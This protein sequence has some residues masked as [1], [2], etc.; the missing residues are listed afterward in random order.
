MTI[1]HNRQTQRGAYRN[2]RIALLAL[3]IMALQNCT[4]F[5]PE[6]PAARRGEMDL[7]NWNFE[8]NGAVVLDGEWEFYWQKLFAPQDFMQ[9]KTGNPDAFIAVPGIWNGTEIR[10]TA[11]S[12]T[13]FATYRLRVRTG[14]E[15]RKLGIK[16][17]DAATA[18]KLW[19]NGH[20][21]ASN[22][23]VSENAQSGVPQYQPQVVAI[24]DDIARCAGEEALLD[25]VIQVSNHHHR[26]GGL[27]E[28]IRLG[29]HDQ[30]AE[31]RERSLLLSFF[32][33][34]AIIIMGMYHV[35][36]YLLRKKEIATLFFAVLA[37]MMSLRSFIINERIL[38][39]WFPAVNWELLS[40]LEYL[41]S[42]SVIAV[43]A[44][45]VGALYPSELKKIP[46]RIIVAIGLLYAFLFVFFKLKTY[47]L[48][49][50][51]YDVYVLIGGGYVIY[52]LTLA[53]L[54]KR[55]GALIALL[56][57]SAFYFTG[58]NDVLYNAQIINTTNLA[59][60]GLFVYIF[61]QSHLLSMRFT[62]ALT[63]V[64]NMREEL[65]DL[66]KNLEQKVQERTEEL[67]AAFE[68]LEAV[69]ERLVETQ[70][71]ILEELELARKIQHQLIPR[72]PPE[73]LN[74]AAHYLPMEQVGGDFFDY[75]HFR[76]SDNIG[77]FMSDVS[78]H[79]VPAAL[80]TSMLKS[81]I[82]QAGT[83]KENPAQLL[84]YLNDN[85]R[86]YAGGN[87][88]TAFYCICDLKSRT[89][90]YCNAGH[91]PPILHESGSIKLLDEAKS[92]PLGIMTSEEI[93]AK[94]K[95][96]KNCEIRISKGGRLILYTDGISDVKKHDDSDAYYGDA[97]MLVFIRQNSDRR[98]PE[99]ID[100]FLAHARAYQG[101]N[102]F[103]D[104]ICLICF[105]I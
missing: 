8:K 48:F 105:D 22:G 101:R 64:E 19:V 24:P 11:I 99:F 6:K 67:Q 37:L 2:V 61:S 73:N 82:L 23:T 3:L 90:V 28:S 44:L 80:I 50:P 63:A 98:P 72:I 20:L 88:I 66:N 81:F 95:G 39:H 56:G 1:A 79:G 29:I 60:Y 17:L 49:K 54:R 86:A 45:F 16:M 18:Y 91:H 46:V 32:I 7:R 27:W 13:G 26:K 53:S 14:C 96:F 42:F 31:M 77:I 21:I 71:L 102:S 36:L 30:L 51:A 104:D 41:T 9:G 94:G 84:E 93:A 52:C 100:N 34:G 40:S 75:I 97:E 74:I 12:G 15:A 4:G 57:M 58:I 76:D 35:G 70:N 69:N 78:G 87:F 55:K 5:T 62:D 68:E 89:I 38:V 47:S 103:D 92:M 10:N 65:A 83:R 43:I 85:I 59:P 25:I 33:A